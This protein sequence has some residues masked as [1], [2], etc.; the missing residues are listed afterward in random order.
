M[1]SAEA[2]DLARE[3][4]RRLIGELHLTE[5]VRAAAWRQQIGLSM[6]VESD[7]AAAVFEVLSRHY[8]IVPGK[9]VRSRHAPRERS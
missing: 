8:V 9:V 6:D 2:E 7:I 3:A 4:A 5:D 1:K